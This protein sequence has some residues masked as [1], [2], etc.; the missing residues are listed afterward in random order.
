M[1]IMWISNSPFIPTGYGRQMK[2]VYQSFP[3]YAETAMVCN[4]GQI[5][6]THSYRNG[7]TLYPS[8]GGEANDGGVPVAIRHFKPD[9]ICTFY[10]PWA[11]RWQ[12]SSEARDIPWVAWVPVDAEP[13]AGLAIKKLDEADGIMSCS[14]WGV[15]V[16]RRHHNLDADFIPCGEDFE[17]VFRPM[18]K[19]RLR[20]KYQFPDGMIFG[21]V[22]D[23]KSF[24]NR[25]GIGEAL[26]AFAEIERRYKD[27]YLYLH[28]TMGRNRQGLDIPA[29]IRYYKIPD[30]KVLWV[31]QDAYFLN[32]I[33]NT[34]M[35]E[36][37]NCMD[38][39]L[40]PSYAEGF[41]LPVIEAQGCGTPVIASDNTSLSEMV[42][43]AGGWLVECQ[44]FANS[45]D[46]V[47]GTPLIADLVNKMNDAYHIWINGLLT[48]RG[49]LARDYTRLFYHWNDN[50]S[51]MVETIKSYV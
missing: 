2:L 35:A 37:Y 19:E 14:R 34:D 30:G 43:N 51:H 9:V 32:L 50:V 23:N 28:T 40:Q 5:W 15:S 46:G 7:V 41:G 27:V 21:L 12:Y 22:G 38:V 47:W 26:A 33:S 13:M 24:P 42:L 17:T 1:K 36:L 10:D 8:T 44:P 49:K 18:D 31:D 11:L 16:L 39:L 20:H 6:Q 4:A 29:L 3:E 25:K 48:N 45:Y